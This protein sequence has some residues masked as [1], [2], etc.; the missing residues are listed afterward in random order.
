[1]G[2]TPFGG[3]GL[4]GIDFGEAGFE[5]FVYDLSVDDDGKTNA[6]DFEFTGTL[7]GIDGGDNI[8]GSL[9]QNQRQAFTFTTTD[10]GFVTPL[11]PDAAPDDNIFG[12]GV[13]G[14]AEFPR[15]NLTVDFF[16]NTTAFDRFEENFPTQTLFAVMDISFC[17]G[18]LDILGVDGMGNPIPNNL[19]Q[20]IPGPDGL[21][22]IIDS[23]DDFL[24]DPNDPTSTV[25]A[26]MDS[27]MA[28][29]AN[30][31]GALLD[32][33]DDRCDAILDPRPD[34]VGGGTNFFSNAVPGQFLSYPLP[35]GDYTVS[36]SGW[37]TVY[38]D[39]FIADVDQDCVL[40][41]T[42]VDPDF[43]AA[44]LPEGSED[45]EWTL[46]V[47]DT[48]NGDI[49]VQTLSDLVLIDEVDFITFTIEEA[50]GGCNRADLAAPFNILNA[51]DINAFFS[52]FLAGEAD[53]NGDMVTN[54]S[55]INAFVAD[56]LGGCP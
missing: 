16:E 3:V 24:L 38:R 28:I 53:L 14:R 44:F 12:M 18:T 52:A 34:L 26:P 40:D 6:V 19:K 48:I 29:W 23:E 47:A 41:P 46:T 27:E 11:D 30:V 37:E 10:D 4:N 15:A 21:P 35:A 42:C 54:S 17:D 2:E 8:T 43:S 45:G 36:L 39:G 50:A 22:D 9:S 49:G 25:Q 20:Q 32:Q 56:F 7:A 13:V 55:D 1:Q 5:P 33:I 51:S 31:D